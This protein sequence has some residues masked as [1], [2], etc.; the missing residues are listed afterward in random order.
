MNTIKLN[1]TLAT[2]FSF[3]TTHALGDSQPTFAQGTAA[4]FHFFQQEVS[5]GGL[6]FWWPPFAN[7]SRLGFRIDFKD[8]DEIIAGKRKPVNGTDYAITFGANCGV[9]VNLE[10]WTSMAIGY[11]G[12]TDHSYKSDLRVKH[13]NYWF[14]DARQ[15]LQITSTKA[16]GNPSELTAEIG[17]GL[18][19]NL[20]GHAAVKEAG[21]YIIP[22]RI[23][24][25]YLGATW[26]I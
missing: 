24:Y 18:R 16:S 4:G 5:G 9:A 1:I 23:V 2:L 20:F 8:Y 14:L 22:E 11:A 26:H 3:V 7:Q 12:F 13:H 19:W 10:Y 6:D 25:P 15:G 17:V 21:D